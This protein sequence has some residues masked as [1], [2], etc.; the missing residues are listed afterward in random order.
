[1]QTT[2]YKCD[3][4]G[5]EDTTNDIA[6]TTIRVQYGQYKKEDKRTAEW[7]LNCRIETG[8]TNPKNGDVKPIDPPLTLED[9]VREIVRSEMG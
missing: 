3:R 4:C 8:L 2:T 7:C 1:M 6:L 9:L 5:A